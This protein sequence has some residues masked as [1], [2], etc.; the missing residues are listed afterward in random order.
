MFR[1]FVVVIR[2]LV[3]SLQKIT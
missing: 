1:P 2:K 3:L